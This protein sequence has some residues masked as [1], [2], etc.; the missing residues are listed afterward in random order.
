MST[1]WPALAASVALAVTAPAAS[2][3]AAP[4]AGAWQELERVVAVIRSP[5]ASQAHVVTLSR[6]RQETRI[7]LVSRGVMS[8]ATQ[9]LGAASLSVGLEWLVEQTLLSDEAAR[10]QVFD[11]D[12]SDAASELA[13]FRARFARPAD[14]AAFLGR[15]DMGEDE[16]EAVLRRA[17]RVRRYLENRASHSGQVSE[18]EVSAWLDQH[19]AEP[20]TRDRELARARLAD[21]RAAAE[22]QTLV[23]DVRARAEIRVLGELG[24][25]PPP[26]SWPRRGA[27]M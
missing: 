21:E 24:P 18:G 13:R 10:L 1:R 8:A 19:V 3:G 2:F 20:G 5:A 12:P 15:W 4:D 23:R 16:V 17:L 27:V 26:T 7:A 9:P 6:L 22:V 25:E 14:Y 11:I